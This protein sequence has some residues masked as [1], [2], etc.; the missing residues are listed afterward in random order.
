MSFVDFKSRIARFNRIVEKTDVIDNNEFI[1]SLKIKESTRDRIRQA[2]NIYLWSSLSGYYSEKSFELSDDMLRDY[3]DDILALPNITPNGLILP[4][5][6]NQ[7]A[8]NLLCQQV[9][10]SVKELNIDDKID[11]IQYPINIRLQRGQRDPAFEKRPRASTKIHTDIWAGDPAG[12]YLTFLA[13]LGDPQKVGIRFLH[14]KNFPEDAVRTLHDY[15]EGEDICKGAE[16]ICRFTDKGWYISDA[17]LLHQTTKN[18]PDAARISI[19][20]RFMPKEKVETDTQEDDFRKPYFIAPEFWHKIGS[21]KLFST[22]E[23]IEEYRGDKNVS[24][25]A[26]PVKFNLVDTNEGLNN[27]SFKKTG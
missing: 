17:Y 16:E 23:V 26:Y 11:R 7:L 10:N 9:S 3:K 5:K 6:D 22:Q 14:Q 19:D 13:V 24:Q 2:L 21:E 4:K 15:L 8:F 18:D 12:G 1:K 25:S 20:F 27:E